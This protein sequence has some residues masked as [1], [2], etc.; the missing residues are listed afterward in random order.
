MLNLFEYQNK[1]K[2]K[3]SLMNLD[4]FLDDIWKKREKSLFYI[5]RD[6]HRN[7]YQQFL[8][9]IYKSN[10]IKSKKYVGVIHFE[11]KKINLLPKVFYSPVKEYSN[12]DINVIQNHIL[13][14]LSYCRKIKFP[15]YQTTLGKK[16]SDFFELLI[17]LFS[18]Y[19]RELLAKSM[20][21]QYEDIHKEINFI[22]GR[23]NTNAY[24][25]ENLS[26]GRWHKLNCSYDEL[27]FDNRFNQIIKHVTRLLLSV[28]DSQDNKKYLKEILFILDDV[29]DVTVTADECL[30]FKFNPIFEDFETVRDYCYLFLNNSISFSYKN[31]LKLFAFLLPMEY[32]FEDFV[33]GFLDKEI[34][35]IKAKSQIGSE[36]LDTDKNFKLSPDLLLEINNKKIIADTKYKIVY[37][38]EKDQKK[39]IAQTDLY[40]MVGYAIRYNIEKI[41]LFYPNTIDY[42][43]DTIHKI[44]IED[45][46]ANGKQ[47]KIYTCQL[48]IINKKLFYEKDDNKKSLIEI[49]KESNEILSKRLVKVFEEVEHAKIQ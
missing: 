30:K 8:R 29:S 5:E 27:V 38:D 7:E 46:L 4:S 19:T 39:G 20:Y 32:V 15:N 11:G 43:D 22:K 49:F 16:R 13:W 42:I 34:N 23:L 44:K 26:K 24:I 33:F 6:P 10:E 3:G 40:Q 21:R 48:P 2:F 25:N 17:Y 28:S 41:I 12:N 37:S 36:Y 45:K 1:E 31:E 47:I 9:L 14:W 35:E 18:K